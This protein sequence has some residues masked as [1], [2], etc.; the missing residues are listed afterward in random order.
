MPWARWRDACDLPG[1]GGGV[2]AGTLCRLWAER[3]GAP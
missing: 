1:D 3:S 2:K